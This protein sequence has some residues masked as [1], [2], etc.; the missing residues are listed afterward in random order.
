MTVMYIKCGMIMGLTK[1]SQTTGLSI[2]HAAVLNVIQ[3]LGDKL[4][5]DEKEL[6]ETGKR[7]DLR[8]S[9]EVAFYGGGLRNLCEGLGSARKR[10]SRGFRRELHYSN[11]GGRMFEP[12]GRV[13]AGA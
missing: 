6:V 12:E 2:S 1:L 5:H 13:C 9:Q 8:R 11:E 3:A 7:E 10:R 4:V